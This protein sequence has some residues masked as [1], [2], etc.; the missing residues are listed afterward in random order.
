MNE[1]ITTDGKDA[2]ALQRVEIDTQIT[3][4]KK[5][6]RDLELFQAN[7][8]AMIAIS[9]DVA[10]SCNYCLTKG[11]KEIW[12]PSIRLAEIVQNN[13]GNMR[14]GAKVMEEGDE[15]IFVEAACHDLE[16]NVAV[17]V[18]VKRR[19]TDRKGKRYGA[20]M[21]QTTTA[22]AISIGIRNA[23]FKIIP[24]VYVQHFAEMAKKIA[25]GKPENF[26]DRVKKAFAYFQN[27]GISEDKILERLGIDKKTQVNGDHLTTLQGIATGIREHHT[28]IDNEF[29][30]RMK[31][32]EALDSAG[33][34]KADDLEMSPEDHER[35]VNDADSGL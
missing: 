15:F 34:P 10:A 17:S 12:G 28:T 8:R 2:L 23:I 21:I 16:S 9:P 19:I 6:P 33:E 3:T 11:G 13:W 26:Q 32:P 31:E 29:P 22:A 35:M 20:D 1:I 18:Q 24:N 30:E 5:Y 27:M 14:T 4:A 7:C 25:L